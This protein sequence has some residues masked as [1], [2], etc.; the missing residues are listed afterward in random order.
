MTRIIS[1]LNFKGGT[2]KTTTVVNLGMALAMRGRRVLAID[3]DPQGSV[4]GWLGDSSVGGWLGVTYE[5]TLADVLLGTVEWPECVVRAR[6]RFDVIP[7]DR[8][9]AEAEQI[10][11]EQ[12]ASPDILAR[13]L[14]GIEMAGYDYVLLD[15]APSITTSCRN[16]RF[17]SHGRYSC[18]SPRSIWHSWVRER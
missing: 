7:S 8:R 5:R 11:I 15:C 3:L 10:L 12:Q 1:V 6:V 17:I 18:R 2:G 4:G 13:C 16:V 14:D 9:L